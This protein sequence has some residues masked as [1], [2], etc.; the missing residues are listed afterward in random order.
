M[1]P[2]YLKAPRVTHAQSRALQRYGIALDNWDMSNIVHAIQN[3][4]FNTVDYA[5]PSYEI[6]ILGLR[7]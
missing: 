5:D 2:A 7:R 3:N 6:R 4:Q 1:P